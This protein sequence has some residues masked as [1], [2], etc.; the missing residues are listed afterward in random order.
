MAEIK[1]K[2]QLGIGK[3]PQETPETT[4]EVYVVPKR[5]PEHII[6]DLDEEFAERWAHYLWQQKLKEHATGSNEPQNPA[7]T[8]PVS[9]TQESATDINDIIRSKTDIGKQPDAADFETAVAA[10]RNN[11]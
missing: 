11:Q 7:Q 4:G 9:P 3:T 10:S 1:T 6:T 2:E 8:Q 5:R